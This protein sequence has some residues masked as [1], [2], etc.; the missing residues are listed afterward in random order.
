MRK[1]L[2]LEYIYL[3]NEILSN[4]SP[5]DRL[6]T[7][8]SSYFINILISVKNQFKKN[9]DFCYFLT[10]LDNLI[11][12]NKI[13]KSTKIKHYLQSL[14][15][16]KI[17]K[18]KQ[19]KEV[20]EQH[21]QVK[22]QL[23]CLGQI[24]KNKI[25]NKRITP[26]TMHIALEYLSETD[27]IQNFYRIN[28]FVFENGIFDIDNKILTFYENNT[29]FTYSFE[30]KNKTQMDLNDLEKNNEL[31]NLLSSYNEKIL[32]KIIISDISI[33]ENVTK[34][35]LEEIILLYFGN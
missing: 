32:E 33:K 29:F 21:L 27:K 16:Y 25:I 26:E 24:E 17:D 9:D 35:E 15:E 11:A 34:E 23:S 22:S 20:Y 3:V 7:L 28:G 13:I 10:D 2:K 1:D 6:W 8:N 18:V 14:N 12:L 30:D 4:K 31:V 5:A 19:K